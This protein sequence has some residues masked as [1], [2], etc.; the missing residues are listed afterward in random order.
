VVVYSYFM[1]VEQLGEGQDPSKLY[2]KL[3]ELGEYQFLYWLSVEFKRL[4]NLYH[5]TKPEAANV[6]FVQAQFYENLMLWVAEAKNSGRIPDLPFP[7]F[8]QPQ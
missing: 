4:G 1:S 8:A 5:E 2:E 6:C 7:K 3:Q